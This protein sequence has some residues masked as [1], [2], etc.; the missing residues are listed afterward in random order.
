MSITRNITVAYKWKQK[1]SSTVPAPH[2]SKLNICTRLYV[3]AS[4]VLNSWG[5]LVAVTGHYCTVWRDPPVANH[6][7]TSLFPQTGSH[8]ERLAPGDLGEHPNR[9][10]PT[11][12]VSPPGLPRQAV[13]EPPARQL[14]QGACHEH[15]FMS[16]V[17]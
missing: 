2:S 16:K 17:V 5:S 11:A 9:W 1:Y 14:C 4:G 13:C 8:S 6:A 7:T 12:L 10:H 3:D 15:G